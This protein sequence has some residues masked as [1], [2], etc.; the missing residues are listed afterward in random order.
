VA[1]GIAL[2]RVEVDEGEPLPDWR[3]FSGIVAMGPDGLS[4]LTAAIGQHE[5]RSIA[6]ARSLFAR[7]LE[8][9]VGVA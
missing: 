8:Q 2:H 9:V 3:G 7:W 1:R 5:Q 4:Q 6:I